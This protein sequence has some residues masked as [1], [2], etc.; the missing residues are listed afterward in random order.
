[1]VGDEDQKSWE[2]VGNLLISEEWEPC[3]YHFLLFDDQN[4][5]FSVDI[6]DYVCRFDPSGQREGKG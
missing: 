2:M 1:M 5:W 4:D 3:Y 6:V